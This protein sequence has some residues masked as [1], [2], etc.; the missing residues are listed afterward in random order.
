MDKNPSP[1]LSRRRVVAGAGTAGALVAA[2]AVRPLGKPAADAAA[3]DPK[4]T[5]EKDGG[6]RL[7]YPVH[8]PLQ[9]DLDAWDPNSAPGYLTLVAQL[10]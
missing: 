7:M 6:Y 9:Q 2:A 5:A 8:F 10:M 1:Q 3:A 4:A